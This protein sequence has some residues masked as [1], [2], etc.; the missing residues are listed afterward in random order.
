[1][2]IYKMTVKELSVAAQKDPTLKSLIWIK[3]V[4]LEEENKALKD[5]IIILQMLE[6]GKK[7]KRTIWGKCQHGI[8]YYE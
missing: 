8:N 6:K 2:N 3:A 4:N 5:F 7:A 1:M